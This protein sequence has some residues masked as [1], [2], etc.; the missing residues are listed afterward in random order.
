MVEDHVNAAQS[1]HLRVLKAIFTVEDERDLPWL[2][3]LWIGALILAGAL[4]WGYFFNW[5]NVPVDYMDWAEVWAARLQAWRVALQQYTL[6]FHLNDAGAMRGSGDRYFA[7]ADMISS[8]QVILLRW[9]DVGTYALINNLLLYGV[10]TYF[11]LLI[12]KKYHFSLLTFGVVF[13]LFHFN[14]FIVTHLSIGHLSWGGYYLFP[15]FILLLLDMMEGN[16]SWRWVASMACLLFFMILQGSF[17]HFIWC[18]LTLGV[19]AVLRGRHFFQILKASF[20]AVLLSMPRLIPPFIGRVTGNP[21]EIDFLGGFPLLTSLIRGMMYNST[22]DMGWPRMIFDSSLGYWEFDMFVGWPGLLYLLGFGILIPI[23]QQI[24]KREFP[25]QI[26]PVLVLAF[27][28]IGDN[29][30][31]V[32]YKVPLLVTSERV[33]SRMFGLG[34]V[35]LI[36]MAGIEFQK[37]AA[38]FKGHWGWQLLQLLLLGW[39]G[40]DLVMHTLRWSVKNASQAFYAGARDLGRIQIVNHP[41]PEYFLAL[42]IGTVVSLAALIFLGYAARKGDSLRLNDTGALASK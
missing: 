32:F 14:G 6:P 40:Y 33:P 11:L 39:L 27:F 26:V 30:L 42:G 2:Q 9:L 34:L 29:W 28:A 5:G 1:I 25:V 31:N 19:V 36:I 23:F 12:R 35:I 37:M 16:Q 8:P 38:K 13:L 21:G 20:F 22:P 17:H 4:L 7:V 3:P 18:G 15:A 24:K 10:A 41:D